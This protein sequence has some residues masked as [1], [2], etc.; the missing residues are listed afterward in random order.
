MMHNNAPDDIT[1]SA[2][3]MKKNVADEKYLSH[4]IMRERIPRN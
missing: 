3:E 1:M 4:A 2:I